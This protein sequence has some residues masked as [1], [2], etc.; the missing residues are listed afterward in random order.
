M[1][2]PFDLS[3]ATDEQLEDHALTV[4]LRELVPGSFL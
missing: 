2:A 1:K 3:S 4:S